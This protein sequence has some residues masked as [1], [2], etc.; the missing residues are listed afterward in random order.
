M[1]LQSPATQFNGKTWIYLVLVLVFG[2]LACFCLLLGPLFL[3]GVLKRA[4]GSPATDAGVALTIFAV[5]FSLLAALALFNILARRRPIIRVCRETLEINLIGSSSLDGVP[6]IPGA[7]RIAWLLVSMQG[8]KQQTLLAPWQSLRYVQISGPPMAR[9]L[10]IT[11]LLYR[12]GPGPA[13]QATPVANQ[14]SFS[15]AAFDVPLD[16][17][18]ATVDAYWRNVESRRALPSWS[19]SSQAA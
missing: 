18:A 5:P 16:R 11:G 10:T 15:E 14:I 17:I 8:F 1:A 4:N 3:F 7:I 6:L 9:T 19:G 12:V 13:A 2:G